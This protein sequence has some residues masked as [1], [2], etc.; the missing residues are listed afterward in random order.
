VT[1]IPAERSGGAATASPPPSTLAGAPESGGTRKYIRGSSLLLGGRFVSLGINLA[2]Q[3]LIVRYL[4]KSDYGAFAYGVGA[5]SIGSSAVLLGLDKAVARFVPIYQERGEPRK[6]FG[7]IALAVAVVVAVG[8]SLVALCYGLSGLLA[9]RVVGDPLA[10]SLLLILIALAPVDALD[11]LLQGVLAVFVGPRA[12]FWRRHVLGP[13]LKLAAVLV[14][15]LSAGD[16]RLLAWGYV[17]GGLLGLATYMALL[18]R[19][20][21]KQGLLRYAR[22]RAG[23]VPARELLAYSVPLISSELVLI[24][25]GS[26]TVILLEH[27]QST[28]AVADYRAVLPFAKLNLVVLQSFTLLFIPVASRMFARNER[29]GIN[30]L[31]WQTALWTSIFSFPIFAATF[32]LARP[33]TVLLFSPEYAGSA[34]ILALLALGHYVHAAVGFNQYTL[35]VCGHVR[36]VVAS[37]LAAAVVGLTLNLLLIPRYG[38]LGAAIGTAGT[39]VLHNLLNHLGLLLCDTGVRLVEWRYLAV[40]GLI[41]LLSGALLLFQWLAAPSIGFGL[42]MVALASLF[43]IRVTRHLVRVDETFPELLRVPLLR[44]LLA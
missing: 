22:P 9:E 17:L 33:V 14:V 38:A 20:W 5:A 12:I 21:S 10:L 1:P 42:V 27:L 19:A 43:L 39:F 30:G 35:R 3:V 31:Y 4:A 15:V 36:Y 23:D 28:T 34:T 6:A 40:Y 11:S 32:S 26:F 44:R 24:L 41:A 8:L 37:D 25:R 2:V 18:G 7:A 13:G 16:V 29:E